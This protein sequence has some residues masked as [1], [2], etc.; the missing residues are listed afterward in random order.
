MSYEIVPTRHGLRLTQHGTVLS[1]LRSTPGP[2]HSVA[3]VIAAAVVVL[4]RG[5]TI[6]LLGFAA[7]GVLA[8]LRA[9]GFPGDVDAVDLDRSGWNL[10]EQHCRDWAGDVSFTCAEAGAWLTRRDR[11]YGVLIEDLSVPVD[12]DVFKPD[13][14]WS[15]LPGLIHGRLARDGVGVFNL[16]HP[17]DSSWEGGYARIVPAGHESRVVE[18]TAYENRILIV[19][20]QLPSARTLSLSIRRELKAIGSRLANE[21]AIRGRKG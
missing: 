13:S 10:F 11:I 7:G 5:S 9:M 17:T 20:P 3:D 14:T 16:L 18:F 4:R 12:G 21:I 6:G 2:T 19:A 1:E 15:D 8:P